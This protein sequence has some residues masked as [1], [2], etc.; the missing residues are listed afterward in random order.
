M[1]E[2]WV[3]GGSDTM[4]QS[5]PAL[6]SSCPSYPTC[7]LCRSWRLSCMVR[8]PCLT[9]SAW[10]L[11]LA[12]TVPVDSFQLVWRGQR[13]SSACRGLRACVRLGLGR[14]WPDGRDGGCRHGD[15]AGYSERREGWLISHP[16]STGG[17]GGRDIRSWRR[18]SETPEGH[19]VPTAKEVCVTAQSIDKYLNRLPMDLSK[20][21]SHV[22]TDI[23]ME[24]PCPRPRL[25]SSSY[26]LHPVSVDVEILDKHNLFGRLED[27]CTCVSHR[28]FRFRLSHL[29][30][31]GCPA[32]R[33]S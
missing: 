22:A 19:V 26:R 33:V 30:L 28:T 15:A 32:R 31:L 23:P 11:V 17:Q 12:S 3:T 20:V 6:V 18:E 1:T 5:T 9:A 10:L 29:P 21:I 4:G 7:P 25:C 2:R 13:W 27:F 8:R 14:A 16:I 24:R